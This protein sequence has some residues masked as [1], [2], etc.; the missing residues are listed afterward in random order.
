MQPALVEK[1]RMILAGLSFFG[2]PFATQAGWP[3]WLP[4]SGIGLEEG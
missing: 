3:E 1:E 2:D 4:E